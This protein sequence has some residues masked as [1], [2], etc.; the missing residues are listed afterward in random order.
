MFFEQ[1]YVWTIKESFRNTSFRGLVQWQD[2]CL[3]LSLWTDP[4]YKGAQNCLLVVL[5]CKVGIAYALL[6]R[7]PSVMEPGFFFLPPKDNFYLQHYVLNLSFAFLLVD[8]SS[9]LMAL[10]SSI[11]VTAGISKM[12]EWLIT[13]STDR[14]LNNPSFIQIDLEKNLDSP[15]TEQ[16]ILH[17]NRP[18]KELAE[19]HSSYIYI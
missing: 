11:R 16:P 15:P 6:Y 17:R 9:S 13:K 8:N 2:S 14:P 5:Y 12:Q 19:H 4:I 18:W 1:N 7:Q 10:S 3:W